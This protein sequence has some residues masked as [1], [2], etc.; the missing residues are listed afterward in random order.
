M[1]AKQQNCTLV[2]KNTDDCF[3]AISLQLRNRFGG[4]GEER[5]NKK[6][7]SPDF[8]LIVV[9][10][11]C[12]NQTKLLLWCYF[13]PRFRPSQSRARSTH[14]T[15]YNARRFQLSYSHVV[16]KSNHAQPFRGISE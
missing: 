6:L 9:D 3:S 8:I 13:S 1:E 10:G 16:F 15:H 2:K 4:K 5:R 11:V 12:A 7:F 14:T